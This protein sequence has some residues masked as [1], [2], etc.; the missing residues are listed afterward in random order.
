V[1]GNGQIVASATSG[2]DGSYAMAQVPAGPSYTLRFLHPTSRIVW[3]RVTDLTLGFGSSVDADLPIDP[4]GVFYD[5]ITRLPVAGVESV[6]V[7]AS[8]TP[9]PDD[10]LLPGQQNQ[11]SGA[12]GLYRFD[13]LLGVG[14]C[15]LPTTESEYR[16]AIV[17]A[18]PGVA[19]STQTLPEPTALDA[20]TC[21]GDAV[22]GPG[23]QV[24]A[25]PDPPTGMA[26]Q[27]YYLSFLLASGD[28]NVVFN[29]IP[30][31]SGGSSLVALTKRALERDASIGDVIVYELDLRNDSG[32]ALTGLTVVDTPPAGFHLVASS[33]VLLRGDEKPSAV[34]SSGTRPVTFTGLSLAAGERAVLRYALRVGAHV[35]DGRHRN[36]A[37]VTRAGVAFSPPARAEVQIVAEPL[38][39][40][41]TVIGKVFHDRDG[42]GFQ[43]PAEAQDVV[44]RVVDALDMVSGTTQLR[45]D[46]SDAFDA[47]PDIDGASALVSGLRVDELAPR[48][49]RSE[50][51]APQVVVR[52]RLRA[53]AEPTLAAE[54]AGGFRVRLDPRGG[55]HHAHAGGVARGQRAER[56]ALWRWLEHENGADWLYVA[57]SNTGVTEE[58][59]A[60]V[61][62]ATVD[63]LLIETDRFGR[64]HLADAEGGRF[65]RGR[66]MIAK[67]D[68]ATL[69]AGATFTTPNPRVAW[70][71]RGVTARVNFGVRLPR[72]V[73]GSGV[74]A[75]I[76]A[77]FFAGAS[78]REDRRPMLR[79]VA[80]R[81]IDAG[82]GRIVV[83]GGAA[84]RAALREAL[85]ALLSDAPLGIDYEITFADTEEDR[86]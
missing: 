63:G 74:M 3:S 48:H 25:Q 11:V 4:S 54:S 39:G 55:V 56:L 47:V 16:I 61:R 76:D 52:V 59:I 78:L 70:V 41:S 12:D 53:P 58:G 65:E 66:N 75:H 83:A 13:L 32:A 77:S 81:L 64:W 60:G 86:P 50:G 9:V 27:T 10:C 37:V 46:G 42:D 85:D 38:L 8:G 19:L 30:L 26:P 84:R 57:V 17:S 71:R 73:L 20:T 43:D 28:Q 14:S 2:S 18:P 34:A 22:P 82:T 44:L 24:Q 72:E 23:C 35:A 68:T 15:A 33:A 51:I 62:V 69:P 5:E 67:L 79:A 7:D 31:T 45:R 36:S 1:D 21:P 40:Q 6:L 80:D 49:H 29:H